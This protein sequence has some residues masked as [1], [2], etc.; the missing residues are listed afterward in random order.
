MITREELYRLVW[1]VPKSKAARHLG[2]S[3]VYLG[4]VCTALD[5]PRPPRG[6]WAKRS[7]GRAPKPP[8][9]PPARLGHPLRWSRRGVDAPSIAL[10][11]RRPRLVISARECG[12]HPLAAY[13]LEAFGAGKTKPGGTI[14]VTRANN[15]I[16]MT[17]SPETLSRAVAAANALFLGLERHGHPVEVAQERMFIRPPIAFR[18]GSPEYGDRAAGPDWSPLWPTIATI[19]GVSIGLAILE[20]HEPVEMQYAGEGKFVRPERTGRRRRG[21]VVG[22]TW[23][24]KRWAPTG[25]L[26]LVAYSPLHSTPWR[27]EWRLSLPEEDQAEI[28]RLVGGL[29]QAASALSSE[30]TVPGA[31]RRQG[32]A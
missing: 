11:Y 12:M 32:P 17:T 14:L 2:V 5:V 22:I 3:D 6:W 15:A 23:K 16:D 8:P 24:E 28:D 30:L 20:I 10:F 26:K 18:H 29:E 1:S 13:A 7:A 27:Q 21:A 19:G 25:R 4:R 9:L 31:R